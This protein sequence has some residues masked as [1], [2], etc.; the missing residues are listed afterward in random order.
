MGAAQR[1]K[2]LVLILARPA[3]LLLGP[4]MAPSKK[5]E[6]FFEPLLRPEFDSAG[7]DLMR[8][9]HYYDEKS[10]ALFLRY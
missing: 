8:P 1:K 9:A 3:R 10:P 6:I 7:I 4:G 5:A 2:S